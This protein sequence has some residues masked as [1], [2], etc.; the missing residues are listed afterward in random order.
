MKLGTT[1]NSFAQL[2]SFTVINATGSNA[3]DFLHRMSTNNVIGLKD[4]EACLNAFLNQ[5]GR[6][7]SLCYV[8]RND[9]NS[10]DLL[11]PYDS[12]VHLGD[13]L[14]QY[15]FSED[16]E[17]TDKS[18]DFNLRWYLGDQ[19]I[20]Y[21]GPNF[22]TSL[23]GVKTRIILR[24]KSNTDGLEVNSAKAIGSE[25]FES[26]RIA[27]LSPYSKNEINLNYQPIQLGL[28]D[29]ISWD[30]G[31]YI[32]QEVISRLESKSKT[33]TALF[34]MRFSKEEWERLVEGET[35]LIDSKPAGTLTSKAPNYLE[36]E[37]NALFVLKRAYEKGKLMTDLSKVGID[38]HLQAD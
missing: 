2:N 29:A 14:D 30:K 34:G 13:W 25:D 21:A 22:W 17:L 19:E 35:I 15:L 6:L 12:D 16:V 28:M 36:G 32:G 18:G 4:G 8:I 5:K 38:S 33:A 20:G 9:S 37:A 31:C 1:L 27:G 7:I 11:V 23:G 26:L 10:Y 24:A 3:G